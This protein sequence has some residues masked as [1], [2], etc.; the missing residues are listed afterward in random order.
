MEGF[1]IRLLEIDLWEE[2]RTA[3]VDSTLAATKHEIQ[4]QQ[5][6]ALRGNAITRFL[7]HPVVWLALGVWLGAQ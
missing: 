1:H 4:E 2:R 3:E 5:I 6:E 7:K